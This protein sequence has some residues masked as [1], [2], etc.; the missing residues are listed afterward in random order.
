M[1]LR[2]LPSSSY[3]AD[4]SRK[5]TETITEHPFPCVRREKELLVG[6]ISP[7]PFNY[8]SRQEAWKIPAGPGAKGWQRCEAGTAGSLSDMGGG[9]MAGERGQ[10]GWAGARPGGWGPLGPKSHPWGPQLLWEETWFKGLLIGHQ[11]DRGETIYGES[12]LCWPHIV[13]VTYSS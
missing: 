8:E 10:D 4:T 7:A 1:V 2:F 12:S 3:Q 6:E 9:R 11:K 5:I 13:T